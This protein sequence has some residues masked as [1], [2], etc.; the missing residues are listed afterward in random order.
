MTGDATEPLPAVGDPA[1][2]LPG[3]IARLGE[4]AGRYLSAR[5]FAAL[6]ARGACDPQRHGA[7]RDYQPLTTGEHLEMLA[8]RAAIT[9][10]HR[11]AAP[12]GAEGT[13]RSGPEGLLRPARLRR[14]P[15]PGPRRPA[16]RHRRTADPAP[17][18]PETQT[19]SASP[20][21][22]RLITAGGGT[23]PS[24]SAYQRSGVSI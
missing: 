11:P 3:Q 9:H 17:V 24:A 21:D 16:P 23:V 6:R 22:R 13:G 1:R 19:I 15:P 5:A 2:A 7:A 18:R 12:A 20:G 4:L 14:P 8:L 10:D